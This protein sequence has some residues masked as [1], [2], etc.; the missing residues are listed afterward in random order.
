MT[1]RNPPPLPELSNEARAIGVIRAIELRQF[2]A[3][4]K[5]ALKDGR[6]RVWELFILVDQHPEVS[7]MIHVRKALE[8]IPKVGPIRADKF[9]RKHGIT[10]S[11]RLR[12]LGARQ[13]EALLKEFG[14]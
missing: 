9:M 5:E 11:R 7:G 4:I 2:R 1:N 6:L 13:R 12:G 3:S 10:D 8:S 14:P